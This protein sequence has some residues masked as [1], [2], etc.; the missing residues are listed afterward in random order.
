MFLPES[1]R[2]FYEKRKM[3]ELK[4]EFEYISQYNGVKMPQKYEFIM[5][6]GTSVEGNDNKEQRNIWKMLKNIRIF[7][8]LV[9]TGLTFSVISL[10]TNLLQYH[11]KYF[12]ANG[13]DMAFLMLH[14]DILGTAV[15]VLLRKLV[16]TRILLVFSFALIAL[17][18]IPLV[19]VPQVDFSTMISVFGC[20]IGISM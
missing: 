10:D 17:C 2:Y 6:D 16:S 8:S 15:A 14:A 18:T 3:D 9:I 19:I 20:Q 1:P 13:Y 7:F 12:K 5:K 11:S 4:Q